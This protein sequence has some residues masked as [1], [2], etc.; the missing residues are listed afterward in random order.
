MALSGLTIGKKIFGV[1]GAMFALIVTLV[2]VYV[3][4]YR[5]ANALLDTVLH[6][7]VRKQTIGA[8]VEL[9]TTEMQG[10]QRGLM[11]SYAMKDPGAAA[12][13]VKLY[14]DSLSTIDTLLAEAKPLLSSDKERTAVAQIVE[15]RNAWQPRFDELR[16]TCEAGDIAKAYE[17]RN[18]NKVLSAKMHAAATT[19]V[20]EQEATI[21][22]VQAASM[23]TSNWIALFAVLIS[24]LLALGAAIIVRKITAQ[25][26]LTI[27]GLHE[28]AAQVA[29]AAGQISLSSQS[30]AQGACEQAASLE[31]TSASSVEMASTTRRNAEN[32]HQAA[33]S[34]QTVNDRVADANHSLAG[35]VISMSEIGASSEKISKII[36][37][38][39]E[40]AF[41]TNILALNA[42]VESARAGEAGSGFAVVADEVRNLAQR[43]TQAAR[44]TAALIEES[45]TR[46][47]E[48]S[49]KLT[50]VTASIEAITEVTKKVRVL[51]DEVEA[52]SKEQAQGIEQI[53]KAVSQ[54]E[55]VSQKTAA[56][57]E[58][59]ASASEELNAQSETLMDV[60]GHLESMVTAG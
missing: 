48:G 18:A 50:G 1:F 46:S 43:S 58:E 32:S 51:V 20:Q 2:S 7:Y 34:M 42:A 4:S 27:L 56:S 35:M 25:L 9:A 24:A 15:S 22:A 54:M 8:R 21:G 23:A 5:E 36:H 59:S 16:Q 60:V 57:A 14:A 11:L 39:D 17:L 19:L 38:I 6:L 26:R 33:R 55:Q 10:A 13:Y 45:I 30:L 29:S 53:A 49:A 28:G 31:Q 52:S 3:V 12:Q 40:I 37:V 41:Q 44:D 47:R